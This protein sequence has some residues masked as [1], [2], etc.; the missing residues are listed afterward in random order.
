MENQKV[1]KHEKFPKFDWVNIIFTSFGLI[2]IV[3]GIQR[4]IDNG[5]NFNHWF[6]FIFGV[7]SFFM[8]ILFLILDLIKSIKNKKKNIE[9]GCVK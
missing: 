7:I 4:I 1:I 5:M 6:W 2:F 3:G 9:K 8:G